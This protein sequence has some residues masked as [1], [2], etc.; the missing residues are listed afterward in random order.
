MTE[1]TCLTP[2]GFVRE[3]WIHGT[4][5]Q[6]RGSVD[7]IYF[8]GEDIRVRLSTRDQKLIYDSPNERHYFFGINYTI[9]QKEKSLDIVFNPGDGGD[10]FMLVRPKDYERLSSY[11]ELY[12]DSNGNSATFVVLNNQYRLIDATFASGLEYKGEVERQGNFIKPVKTGTLSFNGL[13]LTA[14]FEKDNTVSEIKAKNTATSAWLKNKGLAG[15]NQRI[16]LN[17][18]MR[19]ISNGHLDWHRDL[20]AHL[21]ARE[22]KSLVGNGTIFSG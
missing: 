8:C 11:Q 14:N 12:R 20:Q 15:E 9:D 21:R 3:F 4:D 2:H 10:D 5:R 7:R 6:T 1:N 18:W 16:K 22:L 13:S 19:L 17:D